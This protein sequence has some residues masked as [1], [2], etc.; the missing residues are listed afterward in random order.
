MMRLSKGLTLVLFAL[1]ILMAVFPLITAVSVNIHRSIIHSKIEKDL[2]ELSTEVLKLDK[3]THPNANKYREFDL[4][5]HRYDLVTAVDGGTHWLVTAIDDTKE[6]W[7]E[8]QAE[9]T[10]GQSGKSVNWIK[11]LA[12]ENAV[13][14]NIPTTPAS[15]VN[16]MECFNTINSFIPVF[17]PPPEC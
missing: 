12:T 4:N 17:S 11:T 6:K 3:K 5:G 1:A 2:K 9:K 14:L 8:E 16:A 10:D 7:L 13:E 15:L